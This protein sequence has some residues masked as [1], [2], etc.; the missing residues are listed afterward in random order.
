MF[1]TQNLKKV[2]IIT[3]LEKMSAYFP[4]QERHTSNHK[5]ILQLLETQTY[6]TFLVEN[7]LI[8]ITHLGEKTR[9]F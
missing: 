3:Y 4:V 1:T 2:K 5:W 7:Y 8:M 6:P 9:N